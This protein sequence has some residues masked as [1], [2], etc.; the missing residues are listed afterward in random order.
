MPVTAD[1]KE[2]AEEWL[3]LDEDKTTTDEIYKLLNRGDNDELEKRLRYRITFGTAG[4]RGPM[5]AGF[6]CMNSLTVIQASQGLAAYLL[7]NEQEV[8]QRGVVIGRDAR[9]NSAKFAKLAAAAFVAK[10]IKV[11][12]YETPTHTPLVPF[13]VRELGAVA[14]VM[15]TAS[16]NPAQDNGYKVYWSNGCQIIPP[17]DVG[18]A[19]AI[20][21]NLKPV[22]WDTSVVDS[23]SL[24][25]EG[26]LGLIR[27]QYHR[28][29]QAA[30]SPD[31]EKVPVD[32]NLKFVYTPM[33]GVGLRA[34]TRCVKDLGIASQMT[35]VETQAE[36]NPDFPTVKFPNPEEKGALDLA[37]ETADASSISLILASDPDA[38]R[39]ATAEKVSGTW[40]TFTGNELG[41][42][43]ASY[44]FERYPKSKPREKLAMLASTV[45]S[46]ML[47]A[48]AK[49]EGFHYAETLTGFK[50]LGNVAR[51]L[52]K[53]GYDVVFAF[54]EALGYM[55]PQTVHDK[56]SISAAAIFLAAASRWSSQGLTPYAKLQRLY[57]YLG[58][59]E[60]ANTYLISPSPTTTAKVFT[61]IRA[62]GDPYP[63]QL[64]SRR[65]AR[66]RDLTEGY[67]SKSKDH[68]P[69]LPVDKASQMITCELDD[70]AVFTVRGS[71]TEPKIKLYIE[72]SA[73]SSVEAKKGANEILSDLL[74]EWFK[75]DEN[76][77]KL[78]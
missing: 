45:S 71:G 18:I 77:L 26:S 65:I 61:A 63:T 21:E 41:I 46:R 51:D 38:D 33:H 76:G 13:G 47:L 67:D 64:G 42:L 22:T 32:P 28:A 11:W 53:Q 58:H 31:G 17:H 29:I 30:V 74:R 27:D 20:L 50:W 5:Q 35:V 9:H 25:V 39:L 78:A 57:E 62:L 24:L 14:G 69:D 16:H 60:D 23:P 6:A 10:G 59:F 55:I 7:K 54:E 19:K 56:D 12:W 72:C 34:M 43:L 15:I 44:L 8:K 36:P 40:H 37:M 66:W 4:L 73:T 52:T 1:I 3:R 68:V 49:K 70:G 48:L 2:L 75:P